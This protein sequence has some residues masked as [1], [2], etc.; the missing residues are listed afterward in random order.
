MSMDGSAQAGANG[1]P[2]DTAKISERS[3]PL[4]PLLVTL[5]VQTLS[6][7]AA[8]SLPA[9]APAVAHDTHVNPELIGFFISIVYGV[10]ILSALFSPPLIARRGAMLVLEGVLLATV[11][12][13]LTA[14]TGTL[15]AVGL[16]AAAMGLAYGAAAPA[17]THLLAPRTAPASMNTVFSIRQ[18]G[19]PLGG[20]LASL[21][22]PPLTVKVGWQAALLVQ[23]VPVIGLGI[24]MEVLWRR[25]WD[26]S[27]KAAVAPSALGL[28]APIKL[29]GESSPLRRLSFASFIYSG[30]QL[31]FIVFMTTQLT[32]KAGFGLVGAGRV[33]AAYQ[34]SG[35]I[36]RPIWGW[37]S[38]RVMGARWWLG[39][40]GISMCGLAILAGT[41]SRD[42]PG[43]LVVL[44][45]M[46]AGAT[47][48]GFTGIAYGEYARLGGTRRTEATGL[49][50]A[51]MFAGVMV[52]PSVTSSVV[53]HTGTYAW[54]YAAIGVLALLAGLGMMIRWRE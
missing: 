19:V 31:C 10:G 30:L 39:L 34:L 37:L 15:A 3:F 43:A 35:V 32:T 13:I 12:M 33:L 42:W 47:A 38:D 18:I 48:S 53:T 25:D 21:V 23:L 20:M 4:A 5:A 7:A 50:A 2:P 24:A 9:V 40:Q 14:A 46:A 28:L 52:L 44:V 6:T 45:C 8:F 1:K 11:V 16:S 41:F 49:G 54:A 17:S 26:Q 29:L 22:M 27:V 36:A 51:C